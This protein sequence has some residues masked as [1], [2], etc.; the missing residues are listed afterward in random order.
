MTSRPDIELFQFAHSHYNEKVRWA[1]DWKAVPHKR[2]SLLPGPHIPVIRKLTGQTAT[3]VLRIGDEIISGSGDIVLRLDTL[4]PDPPLLPADPEL[5][6]A[7]IALQ[8][9]IDNGLGPAIRHCAFVAFRNEP[10]FLCYLMAGHASLPKRLAYRA[11]LPVLMQKINRILNLD[12][13]VLFEKHCAEITAALDMIARRINA[14][15][16]LAGETFTLADMAAAAIATPLARPAEAQIT[17]PA[18]P[19]DRA[20]DW[21]RKW[22]DHAACDWVREMFARHRGTS[23]ATN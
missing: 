6:G 17:W 9:T 2:T 7:A 11:I 3:P 21:N 18:N 20:A 13:P 8:Q 1:L 12:D 15:G 4:F 14:H 19:P 23:A 5:A 22:R 16:Y 10:A